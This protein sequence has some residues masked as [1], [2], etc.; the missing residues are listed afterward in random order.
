MTWDIETEPILQMMTDKMVPRNMYEKSFTIRLP[1]RS[2]WKRGFE[3]DK[4]GD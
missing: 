1:D 2:E 3:P 4:R